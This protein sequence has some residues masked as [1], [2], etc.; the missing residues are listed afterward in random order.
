MRG[1]VTGSYLKDMQLA[2]QL[3]ERAREEM[4]KQAPPITNVI[5]AQAM[6]KARCSSCNG[7]IKVGFE[8]AIC[9][10]CQ[11]I[12]HVACAKRVRKCG[13]CGASFDSP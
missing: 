6:K 13:S 11:S 7:K 1:S 9:N 3:A 10:K 8:I 12:E 4:A 2:K 5:M